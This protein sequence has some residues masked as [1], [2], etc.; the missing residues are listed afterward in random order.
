VG[1]DN[2]LTLIAGPRHQHAVPGEHVSRYNEH[3]PHRGRDL[4]PPGA[5]DIAP[6]AIADRA[7]PEIRRRRVFGGLIHEYER[8]A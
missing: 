1:A 8:T 4:R 7:A 2:A 3:H 6:A 5:D